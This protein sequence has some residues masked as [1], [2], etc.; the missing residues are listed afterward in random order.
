LPRKTQDE[1]GPLREVESHLDAS[2]RGKAV[3]GYDQICTGER[4]LCGER[5][6]RRGLEDPIGSGSL[7]GNGRS[8]SRKQWEAAAVC[9]GVEM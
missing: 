2:S 6:T 5:V 9:W 7:G 8:A 3:T 1:A 4:P